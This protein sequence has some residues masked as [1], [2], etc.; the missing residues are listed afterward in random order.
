MSHTSLQTEIYGPSPASFRPLITL[1]EY[2]KQGKD[3]TKQELKQAALYYQHVFHFVVLSVTQKLA[4]LW[5]R[6][7]LC[8]SLIATLLL[9]CAIGMSGEAKSTSEGGGLVPATVSV[10]S[11]SKRKH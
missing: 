9:A 11:L 10:L 3:C 2:D 5:T 6:K 8:I 1:Q 4:F 7:A